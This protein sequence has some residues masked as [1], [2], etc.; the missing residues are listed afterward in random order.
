MNIEDSAPIYESAQDN[1]LRQRLVASNDQLEGDGRRPRHHKHFLKRF[2][3]S[4]LQLVCATTS[5]FLVNDT[6]PEDVFAPA[7]GPFE[8]RTNSIVKMVLQGI[9]TRRL[10]KHLRFLTARPHLSGTK[11]S[12]DTVANYIYEKLKE[13]GLDAYEKIPYKIL[14]QYPV[15]EEPNRVLLVDASGAVLLEAKLKEGEIPG[16]RTSSVPGYIAFSA[17][18][19]AEGELIYV[20]HGTQKDFDKLKAND[21]DTFNRICICR[22]GG[23]HLRTA[24]RNCQE[25]GGVGVLFFP[26]PADVS[27]LGPEEVYPRSAFV[28]GT[29]LQ[30]GSLFTY[31]D[32]ETPGYPSVDE[33]LRVER[34]P[35][36]PKI[37]AQVIGYDDAE[38]LLRLLDGKEIF[39]HGGFQFPYRTG[40]FSKQNKE[41]LVRVIVNSEMK[42]KTCY[43]IIGAIKGREQ[44][45]RYALTGNHHDAWAYGAAEPSSGTAALLEV[46]R[47]LGGLRRN[48]WRP[49]RTIVFAF[50]AAHEVALAG[51]QEWLEDK[52]LL[53]NKGAVGYANV[54]SCVSGPT[55]AASAS[56]TLRNILYSATK[57]VPYGKKSLYEAWFEYMF[58]R[59]AK[60]EPPVKLPRGIADTSPFNFYAGIPAV[61]ITFRPDKKG[62]GSIPYPAFHTAYDNIHL[63]ETYLDP[64]LTIT[65]H[66]AQLD[67]VLTLILAES[68]ILPYD[69][70]A[71]GRELQKAVD[72]LKE[73]QRDIVDSKA[74]IKWLRKEIAQFN[75]EAKKWHQWLKKAKDGMELTTRRA[76]NDR[77][78]LIERAFIKLPGFPDRP[79]VRNLVFSPRRR[80]PL[81]VVPFPTVE[82]AVHSTY[83]T[84]EGSTGR[85]EAH[86]AIR[87]AV[88]DVALAT[89]SARLLLNPDFVI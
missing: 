43:N 8:V 77:M 50:W 51:S 19:T 79:T 73:H 29:A 1:N 45:D 66:C 85:H 16:V 53:L 3:R 9:N 5:V 87:R 61:D 17:K 48:G 12:E 36:L 82:D 22:L 69:F 71:L 80:D 25:N 49:R 6:C 13:N 2:R 41:K 46:S 65:K 59:T 89:R 18:G 37:P 57:V 44:P 28:G 84:Q 62:V 11:D 31:G 34:L 67:G 32:P 21:V 52:F 38:K 20:N 30:R 72:R 54:G 10:Q 40:P 35:G 7:V 56:P 14:H 42:R 74:N 60:K 39:P 75:L 15:P 76:I 70:I 23:D 24:V 78:L 33:A 81:N 47:I 83:L 4:K 58:N 63:L 64:N 55:F 68:D 26:D 27:P 86:E 88:N